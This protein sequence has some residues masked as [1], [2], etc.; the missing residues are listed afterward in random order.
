MMQLPISL[1]LTLA[2]GTPAPSTAVR[3]ADDDAAYVRAVAKRVA[4]HVEAGRYEQALQEL[5]DAERDR[6]HAVFVYMRA[7]IEERRGDC[8]RA[9]ALYR[10]FLEHDVPPADA[11]DARRGV[12]RCGGEEGTEVSTAEGSITESTEGDGSEPGDPSG[13]TQEGGGDAPPRRWITDPWGG[14]LVAA[15]VVGV[16]VGAGLIVRAQADAR[17]T[18]SAADL[19]T[20]QDLS[21]SAERLDRAGIIT[22]AVGSA[23]VAAGI[24]RYA[25]I[26]AR[27]RKSLA[28]VP[29][30][31]KRG[32][33]VGLIVRF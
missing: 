16:G 28:L 3:P 33:E 2:L 23:L 30:P 26:G 10:R 17:A 20:H 21:R 1:T 31:V 22:L 8:G 29:A 5:D 4:T 25:L 19:Q 13:G 12:A 14:A 18:A 9:I 27:G 15:G 32:A 7:T 11:D 6:P 24:V